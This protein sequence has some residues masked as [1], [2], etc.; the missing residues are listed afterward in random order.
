MYGD[1]GRL[2]KDLADLFVR[3]SSSRVGRFLDVNPRTVQ[4]W[5][6]GTNG[7]MDASAVPTDL[8][9]KIAAQAELVRRLE[10]FE[11]LDRIR[12]QCIEEGVHAE[13]LAAH[14]AIQFERVTGKTVE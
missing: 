12:E 4:R 9:E 14:L 2:I 11:T 1:D 5:L 6:K 7:A 3:F 8:R 13:V 10:L